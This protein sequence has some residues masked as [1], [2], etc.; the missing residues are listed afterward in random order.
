MKKVV[1]P[2]FAM[3]RIKESKV[4]QEFKIKDLEVYSGDMFT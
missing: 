3:K 4:F 2:E 1:Y